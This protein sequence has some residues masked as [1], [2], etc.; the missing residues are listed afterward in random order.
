MRSLQCSEADADLGALL[1]EVVLQAAVSDRETDSSDVAEARARWLRVARET[2]DADEM[3]PRDA[4][5][6]PITSA[7]YRDLH[8]QGGADDYF[9]PPSTPHRVHTPSRRV[10]SQKRTQHSRG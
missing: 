4:F 5:W 1:S 2:A 10:V 8:E 3:M 6:A 7:R 9:S